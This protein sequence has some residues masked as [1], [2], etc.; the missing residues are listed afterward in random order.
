M[1]TALALWG[2]I[3]LSPCL[4]IRA[5]PF[6][7]GLIS[8]SVVLVWVFDLRWR[9]LALCLAFTSFGFLI[10]PDAIWNRSQTSKTIKHPLPV[11]VIIEP[12]ISG[13]LAQGTPA[14]IKEV[15]V[16]PRWLKNRRV[17]VSGIARHD[18]MGGTEFEVKGKVSSPAPKLNPFGI[19]LRASMRR[20]GISAILVAEKSTPLSQGKISNPIFSLRSYLESTI[21][22]SAGAVIAGMLKALLLGLR[23]DLDSEISDLLGKAGVYH[24]LAISGLHVGIVII[25]A[26]ILLDILRINRRV[27]SLILIFLVFAYVCLTGWHTSAQRALVLFSLLILMALGDLR[28]DFRNAISASATLLLLLEPWLAWDLGFQ[29]SVLAVLG[30]AVFNQTIAIDY[31]ASGWAGFLKHYII[32]AMLLSIG[33]Q[34]FS[35]PLIAYHFLRLPIFSPLLNLLAIPLVTLVVASGFEAIAIMPFCS[36]VSSTLICG[37]SLLLRFLIWVVRIFDCH[38]QLSIAVTRPT[39]PQILICASSIFILLLLSTKLR[40]ILRVGLTSAVWL[41]LLFHPSGHDKL[42]IIFLAVGD[43]DAALI[44]TPDGKRILYDCGPCYSDFSRGS[45]LL[46]LLEIKGIKRLD[47]VVITHPHSDHYGG[48]IDILNRVEI[49]K[50]VVGSL[51]GESLYMDLLSRIEEKQVPLVLAESGDSI[52]L[53]DVTISIL[54]ADGLCSDHYYFDPNELSIVSKVTYGRFSILLAADAP[55]EVQNLVVAESQGIESLILKVAHHGAKGS[56]DSVFLEEVNPSFA[57]I[58]A[59]WQSKHHPHAETLEQLKRAGV[60][61]LVTGNDG[62][63][64]IETNGETHRIST[65]ASRRRISL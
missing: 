61:V 59:G 7:I 54:K 3:L 12:G 49:A 46:K 43:A 50:V 22:A 36:S 10:S 18:L 9:W 16:G 47:C 23:D 41:A 45:P 48:L 42:H 40:P 30:I 35:L 55:A 52:R 31:K 8:A 13:Q 15:K 1:A 34:T 28:I 4:P 51:A 21:E 37:S 63:I 64:S 25:L 62:A 17:L 44:E 53:G 32:G 11:V 58:T 26:K 33:A 38:V 20:R 56:I 29:L 39:M 14:E 2:A 65:V 24:I 19:D 60:E 6:L 5:F 57:I 27:S